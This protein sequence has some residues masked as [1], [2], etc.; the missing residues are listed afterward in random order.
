MEAHYFGNDGVL[1]DGDLLVVDI[2]ATGDGWA[3]DLTRTIPV[4]PEA[5]AQPHMQ[6]LED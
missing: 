1:T 2:G 6:P 4:S 3:S 5:A